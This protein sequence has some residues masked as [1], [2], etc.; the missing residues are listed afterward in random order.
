[1]G[2]SWI[3]SHPSISV[4]CS[5][6]NFF[7]IFSY[8]DD[9]PNLITLSTETYLFLPWENTVTLLF[10][11]LNSENVDLQYL[12]CFFKKTHLFLCVGEHFAFHQYV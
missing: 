5:V 11:E 4:Y 8:I 10:Q 12:F 1:M 6:H 3:I 9:L 7:K 2:Y